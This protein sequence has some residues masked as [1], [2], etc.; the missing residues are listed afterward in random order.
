F[1]VFLRC[2]APG[3]TLAQALLAG[4]LF[5]GATAYK[6]VVVAAPTLVGLAHIAHPPVGCRRRRAVADVALI[7]AV[8]V[9]GW[10]VIF[11]Y[12]H[13][14][15]HARDFVDAV[16]RFNQDYAGSPVRNVILQFQSPV[17]F[18]GPFIQSA[19]LLLLLCALGLV[20]RGKKDDRNWTLWLAHVVAMDI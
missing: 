15:G 17:R 16:F 1:A 6:Q 11:T 20:I 18:L 8:G 4:F 10:L 12:F 14:V 5:L 3:L 9:L 13:V 7:G 2:R 19:P